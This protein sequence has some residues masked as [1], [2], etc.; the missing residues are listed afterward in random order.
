MTPTIE[1][2][3]ALPIPTLRAA[4]PTWVS[5]H[6]VAAEPDVA[7]IRDALDRHMTTASDAELTE[8]LGLFAVAGDEYRMYPAVPFARA[9]TRIFMRELVSGFSLEGRAHLLQFL[10]G[11]PRR[12]LIVCNHLSYTD[13]QISDVVL[14]EAGFTHAADRLVAIAGPKVYTD[15][16]RR[17]AAISLNTRKTVQSSTVATEQGA[18]T[19]RELATIAL[20]TLHD[21]VRLMD[22]GYIVLLYPE[23]TRSR[24][25]QLQPFLRAA[26]RYL[27]IEGLHVLPMGQ[28][29]TES[30]FPIDDPLMYPSPVRVAFGPEFASADFPGKTGALAEAHRRLVDVLPEAYRPD[31]GAPAVG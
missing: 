4:L 27:Q 18:L 15:A 14:H 30:V 3:A 20:E 6:C 13:T 23:G 24:S 26:G 21:C 12:R 28:T 9:M 29:G 22:E 17:L 19:G 7:A 10:D 31:I 25:G 8:L 16:W 5:G 2:V 11:G 1:Q